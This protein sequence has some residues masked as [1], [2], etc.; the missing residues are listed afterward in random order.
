MF[1]GGD[2]IDG[3]V[4]LTNN[5]VASGSPYYGGSGTTPS[6]G[7]RNIWIDGIAR[8]SETGVTSAGTVAA[9]DQIGA[10]GT[11]PAV[12]LTFDIDELKV[13]GAFESV[14]PSVV[15]YDFESSVWIEAESRV[16]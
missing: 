5:I 11:V 4:Q 6:G 7:S 9:L 2:L 12:S 8:E 10:L 1:S 3:C 14:Q 15:K 16:Y 13:G